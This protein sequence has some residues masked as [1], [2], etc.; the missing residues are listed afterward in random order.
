M[1]IKH[2]KVKIFGNVQ[3]IGFRFEAW[4][5]ASRLGLKGFVRNESDGSVY[6]EAEGNEDALKE[7]LGWCKKGPPS[8][9]IE[10][11]ESDLSD[12]LKYFKEFR[13]L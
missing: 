12:E 10:K 6:A 8:A 9:V 2:L 1:P 4:Q 11:A 13:M 5:V 3:G 7:F